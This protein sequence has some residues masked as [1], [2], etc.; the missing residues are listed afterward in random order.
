M[1]AWGGLSGVHKRYLYIQEEGGLKAPHNRPSERNQPQRQN[2]TPKSKK[3]FKN[4]ARDTTPSIN[5]QRKYASQRES[6]IYIYI[7]MSLCRIMCPTARSG[8]WSPSRT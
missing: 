7:Y 3:P 1:A 4:V 6:Y 5:L 8:S 2:Q